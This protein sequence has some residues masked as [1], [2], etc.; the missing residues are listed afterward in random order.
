MA[1]ILARVP[2]TATADVLLVSAAQG[3]GPAGWRLSFLGSGWTG[4]V[5]LKA[6]MAAPGQAQSLTAIPFITESTGATNSASTPI[7]A[8]GAFL[9]Q[10]D[11]CAYD[12]YAVYTHTA[13]SC[14]V[15]VQTQDGATATGD[16]TAANLDGSGSQNTFGANVPYT[17]AYT[18]PGALAITGALTG[19]PQL[20]YST[21]IVSTTALATPSALAATAFN[22]FAS[23]VSGATLMGYGTTADVTLKNRAGTDVLKIGPNTTAAVFAGT[24]TSTGDFTV[25]ASTFVVTAATGEVASGPVTVTG[26]AAALATSSAIVDFFNGYARFIGVGGDA[27]TAGQI[28]F[29]LSSNDASPFI[30]AVTLT[31]TQATVAL[32]L[33]ITGALTGVTDFTA[34]GRLVFAGTAV[35]GAAGTAS[36]G[37][38]TRTTIGA[39]GAASALTANPL[40]YLDAYV[41][42]TAVQIPYYTRGA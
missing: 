21:K 30:D 20:T 19:V 33:A 26:T 16:L 15:T 13:G 37:G 32:P 39:N 8:D 23:T 36:I 22:A 6:N 29:C 12:L 35:T 41:A 10:P 17:G 42:G 40:G 14:V 3:R 25:G 7:T 4:S 5:V 34:S 27:A 38:V 28:K 9:V 11:Y 2:L 18:F 1:T 24:T 31:S